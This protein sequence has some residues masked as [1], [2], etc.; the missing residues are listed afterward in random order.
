MQ[1][2]LAIL[3]RAFSIFLFNSKKELLL[4][5]RSH[6]KL[7]FPNVWSNSCCSHPHFNSFEM[8]TENEFIG[9]KRAGLRKIEQELGIKKI[10]DMHVMGRFIYKAN[11]NSQWSE[12]ELDYA[13]VI[14][15][16]DELVCFNT[17]EVCDIRFVKEEELFNMMQNKL[18][19]FSPWFTLF[20]KNNFLQSWWSNLDNLNVLKDMKKIHMFL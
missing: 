10:N 4:Q 18:Y 11:Y 12:H 7:T 19:N 16:C 17:N 5:K 2:F 8:D 9:I 13:I 6:S 3:H 15:N 20:T 14:P 1:I